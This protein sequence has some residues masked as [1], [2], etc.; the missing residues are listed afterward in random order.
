MPE[1]NCG[2]TDDWHYSRCRTLTTAELTSTREGVDW[3]YRNHYV[4]PAFLATT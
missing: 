1:C 4:S 2:R 3:L